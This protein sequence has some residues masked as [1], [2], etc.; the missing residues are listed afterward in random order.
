MEVEFGKFFIVGFKGTS[1]SEEDRSNL[2]R[3]KP[4][5][6]IFF[7]ENI[8]SRLQVRSLVTE[9]RKLLG[10]DI[11]IT[12]DQEGG[13]VERLR[14]LSTSL[15]SLAALGRSHQYIKEHSY[16]LAF[17][18]L[19]LGFNMVLGPC[20]DLSSNPSN[21]IIGTRSLGPDPEKLSLWLPEIIKVFQSSGLIACV[22]HFPGHGDSEIDS[23]E[24]LPVLNLSKSELEKH[25]E[26]F[27]Y[28][29]EAGVLS[30]MIGHLLVTEK[31]DKNPSSLSYKIIE[32]ELK[33]KLKFKGLVITDDLNMG[34]L[35]N[36]SPGTIALKA[37]EAGNH[38]LLWNQDLT[39]VTEALNYLNKL[40]EEKRIFLENKL[41]ETKKL[42]NL[43]LIETNKKPE[44]GFLSP[45]LFKTHKEVCLK[46]CMNSI[47]F[48]TPLD[49]IINSLR[50]SDEVGREITDPRF[51]DKTVILAFD[52]PKIE[53]RAIEKAAINLI[54]LA[55]DYYRF[56]EIEI[57][58][59]NLFKYK[60]L[61]ILSFQTPNFPYQ[62]DFIK[63]LREFGR[64][65]IIQCSCDN[66][67]P[68]AEVDIW[69]PNEVHIEALLKRILE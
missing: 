47:R 9:F 25:I 41:I 34:A 54:G 52:H 15:P 66:P 10:K 18:L 56:G 38:L 28:S 51:L 5:G 29:I 6:I 48:N 32:E 57:P 2:I 13:K 55:L 67:D 69:G 49:E 62:E 50:V 11:L 12:V 27:K 61:I 35:N 3:I 31:D 59:D 23:H 44:A 19:D 21:P 40:P 37:L 14:K 36:Y 46:I 22:K 60:N 24:K 43:A 17:E 63:T 39:K 8:Q 20:V 16:I 30:V 45:K 58:F 26:P 68:E 7:D 65:N 4:A 53:D 64:W 42:I 1:L 33:S